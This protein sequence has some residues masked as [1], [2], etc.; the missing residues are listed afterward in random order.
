LVVAERG[1]TIGTAL[2]V[3]GSP[4]RLAHPSATEVLESSA[5]DA[6]DAEQLVLAVVG[7]VLAEGATMVIVQVPGP[8]GALRPLLDQG[9]AITDVDVACASEDGLLADP[10]RHTMHGESRI[11]LD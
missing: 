9:F 2:V 10:A 1:R 8:H 6:S 5:H 3:T 4:Q 7:H 11:A